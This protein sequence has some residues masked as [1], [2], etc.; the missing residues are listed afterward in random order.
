MSDADGITF[1]LGLQGQLFELFLNVFPFVL[2]IEKNIAAGK[3]DL[4]R[5]GDDASPRSRSRRARVRC[6]L[7]VRMK[8][9]RGCDDGSDRRR[10]PRRLATAPRIESRPIEVESMIAPIERV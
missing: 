8:D 7:P 5:L 1:F 6:T 9:G 3:R 4:G 10:M 2:I